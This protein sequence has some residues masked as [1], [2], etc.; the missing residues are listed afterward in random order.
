MTGK[1]RKVFNP[2]L[3][4]DISERVYRIKLEDASG[5][6]SG[7]VQR[8]IERDGDDGEKLRNR[9][10]AYDPLTRAYLEAL[11]FTPENPPK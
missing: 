10:S 1:D 6:G 7:S 5:G 3:I 4:R 2:E 11:G 9:A 8:M